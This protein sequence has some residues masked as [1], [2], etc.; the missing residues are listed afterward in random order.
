MSDHRGDGKQKDEALAGQIGKAWV[1][2]ME[3]GGDCCRE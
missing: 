1:G 3:N 2:M